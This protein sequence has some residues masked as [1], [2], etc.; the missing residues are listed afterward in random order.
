MLILDVSELHQRLLGRLCGR[1]CL[2]CDRAFPAEGTGSLTCASSSPIVPVPFRSSWRPSV[3]STGAIALT[4]GYVMS[5]LF[6]VFCCPILLGVAG[7]NGT[8]VISDI[9]ML[10]FCLSNISQGRGLT[11]ADSH[12]TCSNE[13][14]SS[15]RTFDFACWSNYKWR[16]SRSNASSVH[17]RNIGRG[18][19][20]LETFAH[21]S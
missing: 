10:V 9:T 16:R 15:F 19:K 11:I 4:S 18:C 21:E 20:Q 5:V 3:L 1:S 14:I 7:A 13:K 12:F 6:G 17:N 8:L 2:S